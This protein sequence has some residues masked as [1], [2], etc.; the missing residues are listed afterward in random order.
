MSS[1]AL[2]A[3][4]LHAVSRSADV[5]RKGLTTG[6]FRGIN[7]NAFRSPQSRRFRHSTLAR[8]STAAAM[9]SDVADSILKTAEEYPMLIDGKLRQG[10][11]GTSP[12]VNPAT[13]QPF[14]HVPSAGMEDLNDAVVAAK[15]AFPLW[16]KLDYDEKVTYLE[17]FAEELKK[18]AETIATLL[19]KEQGKPYASALA[20][21]KASVDRI[22]TVSTLGP[23]QPEVLHEDE[24]TRTEVH[25]V[26]RGVAAAITPWNFPVLIAASKA[27]SAL[28]SGNTVVIKPSPFTP[29]ST[30]AMGKAAERAG[31]PA[32]VLN[33]VA[34]GDD[35]GKA[36]AEHDDVRHISFTGSVAT[37]KKVMATAAA[38]LKRVTLELGGNDAAIVLDD[39]DIEPASR[40]IFQASMANT[41]QVCTA[42]K[43]LYVHEKVF[44]PLIEA[45]VT[46]AKNARVGDGLTKGVTHGP[47]N[48][49]MQYDIVT[50]LLDDAKD[51]GAKVLCGGSA[52]EGP[53]YFFPPTL[54]TGVKE[55]VRLVDEEQFGPVLPVMPFSD[56]DDAVDRAN[57]SPF[58]LG[59]SVWTSDPERGAEIAS[60]LET[61][62]TWVNAH[63]TGDFA[64]KPPP[65]G[66][67]KM[68]GIGREH[69]RA[70]LEEYTD[71]KTIRVA[72]KL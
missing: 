19:T 63:I 48:N 18:D 31:L 54:V 60:R 7:S 16:S 72:K 42:I 62:V 4:V 35:L 29:L 39:V 22:A 23:L 5:P 24:K 58:G 37:G 12:V 66:G 44:D 2:R 20:E 38:G 15:R 50:T 36:L 27:A 3:R 53:G 6:H 33:I 71:L 11:A 55:G 26:P 59:G 70:G 30:L 8:C 61:G 57:A 17:K 46:H 51:Q 28:L 43:R 45:L 52:P 68:S 10:S 49:K 64:G 21:V 34:G 56:I 13:E 1:A 41:G 14:A 67:A 25:R 69:G 40:K 9:P 65:F 32:G 47:L